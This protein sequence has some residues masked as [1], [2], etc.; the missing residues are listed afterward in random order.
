MRSRRGGKQGRRRAAHEQRST[1]LAAH[2]A[3]GEAHPRCLARG[4]WRAARSGSAAPAPEDEEEEEEE[5]QVEHAATAGCPPPH[6]HAASSADA[7]TAHPGHPGRPALPRRY[8]RGP[9]AR[10]AACSWAASRRLQ[11]TAQP[12]RAPAWSALQEGGSRARSCWAAQAR[13]AKTQLQATA[14][15][16]VPPGAT[17]WS[18]RRRSDQQQGLQQAK[19]SPLPA[20][21]WYRCWPATPSSSSRRGGSA[22]AAAPPASPATAAAYT[23]CNSRPIRAPAVAGTWQARRCQPASGNLRGPART[24][25]HVRLLWWPTM[26]TAACFGLKLVGGRAVA[27]TQ[28][29]AHWGKDGKVRHAQGAQPAH[30]LLRVLPVADLQS[31]GRRQGQRQSNSAC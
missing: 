24:L 8:T 26:H 3:S 5:E 9:P 16:R 29:L 20:T 28:G 11:S 21:L 30:Q 31:Q 12:G 22:S 17:P 18:A 27:L 10:A 7:R 19:E 2:V 13:A 25:R 4:S 1:C 14:S 6:G 23:G 15:E